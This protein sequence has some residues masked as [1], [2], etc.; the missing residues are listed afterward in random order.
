MTSLPRVEIDPDVA[1]ARTLPSEV[2]ADPSWHRAIVDRV[3][4]RAWHVVSHDGLPPVRAGEVRGLPRLSPCVEEPLLLAADDAGAVRCLSNV[5]THRGNV[6]VDEGPARPAAGSIRCG[7]HGRRF[8]LDGR[9]LSMPRSEGAKDFPSAADDLPRVPLETFGRFHFASVE[10]LLPFERW[11]APAREVLAGGAAGWA[12]DPASSR[13]YEVAAPWTLYV[14]NYLEGFHVPFLHG[15]L[16]E[17]LDP[18]AYDA[19]PLPGGVLQLGYAASA[20]EPALDVRPGPKGRGKTVSAAWLWL[21]PTTMLNVYPWGLSLN[22]VEP[23][24]PDRT[25]V[26]FASFVRDASLRKV[27]AGADL[28]RVEREDEA[29]VERVARGVRSSLYRRGRYAP[30]EEAGVHRFHRLLAAALNGDPFPPP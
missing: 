3:L 25:R 27:G 13:D 2:Y 18:G 22:V 9:F 19:V 26:R 12:P 10:P 4:R 24:G 7:Y 11:I 6:L 20:N 5:C 30:S 17:A 28:D 14:D 29:V 21:F 8:A 1:R 16:A 23:L 15:G